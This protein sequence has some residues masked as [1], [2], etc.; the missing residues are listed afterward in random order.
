MSDTAQITGIMAYSSGM[1][2]M[3]TIVVVMLTASVVGA[4]ILAAIATFTGFMA[5]AA[6]AGS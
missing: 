4:A 2:T 1:A 6:S 5:L 3:G